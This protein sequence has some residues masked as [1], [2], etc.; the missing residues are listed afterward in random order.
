MYRY[1]INIKYWF[2]SKL[3]PPDNMF[4]GKEYS[5][6]A[7]VAY[8]EED[9]LWVSGQLR[10]K[11]ELTDDPIKLCVHNRDFIPGKPIHENTVDKI[12]ESR[13]ILLIIS[14]DFL[15]CTYGPLEIEYAGIND[16]FLTIKKIHK[17]GDRRRN[18]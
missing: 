18:K 3:Q 5:Y 6:D 1:R 11:M 14:I 4:A 10:P 13:K 8:T 2:Y 9:Y 7:F 15:R 17:Y 16:S 12:R